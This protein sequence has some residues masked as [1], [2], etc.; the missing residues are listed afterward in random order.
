WLPDERVGPKPGDPADVVS[1]GD[2]IAVERL[3]S[4]QNRRVLDTFY[5]ADGRA[6]GAVDHFTLRQIPAIEGALVALD[7]HTG[8]VLAMVGGYDFKNSQFNR[9][10][11]AQRQPGS[12]FKPFVYAAALEDGFTPSS[13]VLDAPFVID[14]GDGQGKWKPRNSSN[15]FYGP[16]TLRLG[17]E[18]SR[19]L[20]TIRVAQYIG[21]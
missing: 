14:Q 3:E 7:P 20:M 8:R 10:T 9:A 2:V 4:Q 17:L 12:A 15:R 11:Q 1:M 16:S 13:L 21:I 6:V 18:K 5:S 19:N